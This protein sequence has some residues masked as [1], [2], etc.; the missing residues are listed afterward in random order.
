MNE[1]N[2]VQGRTWPILVREESELDEAAQ[3]EGATQP[4]SAE[5]KRRLAATLERRFYEWW[6]IKL[7]DVWDNIVQDEVEQEL[8][9]PVEDHAG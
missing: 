7:S 9:G 3:G 6:D 4:L 2:N 8:D 5:Q 1:T